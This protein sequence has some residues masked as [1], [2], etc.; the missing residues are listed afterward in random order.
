MTKREAEAAGYQNGYNAAQDAEIHESDRRGAGC[1]CGP[2]LPQADVPDE[3]AECVGYAASEAESNARQ[4]SGHV[5]DGL[6][7]GQWD[8][9]E[10]GVEKG[11]AAG[12]H[13]RLA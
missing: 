5:P 10:A 6:S 8:A 9:Y 4:F 2:T 7:A 13:K 1:A 3:C 11:I 12:T